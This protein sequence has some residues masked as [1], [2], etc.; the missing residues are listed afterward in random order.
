[1]KN[2][3]KTKY[4][5]I[6]NTDIKEL[7]AMVHGKVLNIDPEKILSG[8]Y[9]SGTLTTTT[10]KL[11]VAKLNPEDVKAKIIKYVESIYSENGDTIS[12]DRKSVV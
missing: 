4:T 7:K 6:N 2:K 12:K 3:I 5:Y 9:V 10:K 1:M 8:A 11:R